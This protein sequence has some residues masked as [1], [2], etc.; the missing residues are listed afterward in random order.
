M[1]AFY[2][3]QNAHIAWQQFKLPARIAVEVGYRVPKAIMIR[4]RLHKLL[5]DIEKLRAQR[6]LG[7]LGEHIFHP[8]LWWLNRR[9]VAGG[10]AVGLFCGL[11]PGPL[12]MGVAALGALWLR[13][14]LPVALVTT[15]Y[16]NPFTIVPLYLLAYQLG[17]WVLPGAAASAP[18]APVITA[19]ISAS[20][21]N[22]S[23]WAGSLGMPL[24]A[25][26]PLL[27]AL[28]ATCGYGLA[29]L[30]WSGLVRAQWWL[31]LRRRARH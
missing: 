20:L 3:L 8:A 12:Q 30:A 23:A 4:K 7:A 22:V 6:T 26:V 9:T 31:R 24:L 19:D 10:F 2:P 13:T 15:L 25:G 18:P 29:R 1:Q 17:L 11:I 21:A 28:L 14:N 5:P 27:A 16:T